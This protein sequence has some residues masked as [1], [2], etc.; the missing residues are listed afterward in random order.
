M[1]VLFFVKPWALGEKQADHD[2]DPELVK[3]PKIP[4]NKSGHAHILQK[5][6]FDNPQIPGLSRDFRKICC[7]LAEKALGKFG[8]ATMMSP[9][10]KH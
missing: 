4:L 2:H 7:E 10:S 5:C 6:N 3:G 8:Y 1:E 9:R